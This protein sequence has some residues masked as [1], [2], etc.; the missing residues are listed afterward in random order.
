MR[1]YP[2]PS[3]S[4]S[5]PL[6]LPAFIPLLLV[7]CSH[8]SC[9]KKTHIRWLWLNLLQGN[10]GLSIPVTFKVNGN[11]LN[12]QCTHIQVR[13]LEESSLKAM[14]IRRLE[15]GPLPPPSLQLIAL[16]NSIP[17]LHADALSLSLRI[18]V[19]LPFPPPGAAAFA[20]ECVAVC[21]DVL[22]SVISLLPS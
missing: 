1:S 6:F 12:W 13:K 3:R 19:S 15:I 16:Y 2:P 14:D 8:I 17:N 5:G 10:G 18:S 7:V 20:E 4:T 11:E 21:C 22:L 9:Q